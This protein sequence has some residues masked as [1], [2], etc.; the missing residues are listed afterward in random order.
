MV[1]GNF[2]IIAEKE[3][4]LF[5]LSFLSFCCLIGGAEPLSQN[6]HPLYDTPRRAATRAR[7]NESLLSLFWVKEGCL[8]SVCQY[9]GSIR[10]VLE[11]DMNFAQKNGKFIDFL[12]QTSKWV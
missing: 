2:R 7:D 11:F 4:R 1:R 9:S 3:R 5:L 8:G 6:F 10:K 12:D